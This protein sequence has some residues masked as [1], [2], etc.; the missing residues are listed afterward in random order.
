MQLHPVQHELNAERVPVRGHER[1]L[2]ASGVELARAVELADGDG[3]VREWRRGVE[4]VGV[5]VLGNQ[6]LRDDPEDLRP[7]F[8]DGV[9]APVTGLVEGLVRRGIDGVI[10]KQIWLDRRQKWTIY[11]HEGIREVPDT[12]SLVSRPGAHRVV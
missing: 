6:A 3:A 10:L 5:P 1:L 2:F 11:T 4:R 7:N 8:A 9:N 12:A